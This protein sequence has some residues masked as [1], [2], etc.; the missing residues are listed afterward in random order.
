MLCTDS[1]QMAFADVGSVRIASSSKQYR[2]FVFKFLLQVVQTADRPAVKAVIYE[3]EYLLEI[4]CCGVCERLFSEY[5]G[6]T[7]ALQKSHNVVSG[8]LL[9]RTVFRRSRIFRYST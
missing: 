5:L 4:A 1:L 3:L 6:I 8:F 2:D 9:E 7:L